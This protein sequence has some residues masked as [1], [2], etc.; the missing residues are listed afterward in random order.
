MLVA[1]ILIFR[2]SYDTNDDSAMNLIVA[3]KLIT[4]E[5]DE[6]MIFTHVA[7]GMVL[8]NLY[9]RFPDLPWYALYLFAVQGL[10]HIALLYAL[11]TQDNRPRTLLLFLLY[12]T[13]IGVLFLGV[14]QFTT[15]A[16]LVGQ[17]GLFLAILA[18]LRAADHKNRDALQLA[19]AGAA[20]LLLSSMIRWPVFFLVVC[21]AAPIALVMAWCYRRERRLLAAS[22][23]LV[24]ATTAAAYGLVLLNHA[25][26]AADPRWQDF[27]EFNEL[28]AKFNDLA[29]VYYS[30]ET[31]PV[32]AT[33]GWSANDLG[34]IMSWFYDDPATF[35]PE[36]LQRI[37]DSYAWNEGGY[38]VVK[39]HEFITEVARDRRL[40]PLLCLLPVLYLAL[41]KSRRVH[42]A[43]LLTVVFVVA[44]ITAT[45][46][47]R[48]PPPAR[49][50]LPVLA[51]PSAL[52]LFCS[53]WH[54]RG[55]TSNANPH[56]STLTGSWQ[57]NRVGWSFV[58]S[59]S[60]MLGLYAGI[61]NMLEQY[62]RGKQRR[63]QSNHFYEQLARL[64]P[65][66][67]NL[68]VCW[69]AAMPFEHIR[70]IDNL[71][72]LAGFRALHMGWPQQCPFHDDMKERFDVPYLAR[73]LYER[74]NVI[75]IAHPACLKLYANYV[76][77]HFSTEISFELLGE[78]SEAVL[79]RASPT[80]AET[81]AS[82]RTPE[83][84]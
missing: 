9:E 65:R 81:I 51:F 52:A 74:S 3:G 13:V 38:D 35:G 79:A 36:R 68:Y 2:P 47:L 76:R 77:E 41:G 56:A 61:L 59:L 50:Y 44:L 8:K 73:Q 16:F 7:I 34:M 10:A 70:P 21:L 12:S 83:S 27:Y 60:V 11:I 23:G 15:T 26:Y 62:D 53:A 22:A 17:S 28:R 46:I 24:I 48:K 5:P 82:Q 80:G 69:G 37:L 49:V 42:A 43:V 1:S 14:L 4:A 31:A 66:P 40:I 32:L 54:A 64:D 29:W 55:S 72:W 84:Q 57:W 33:N 71:Q 78:L 67:D 6:H 75:L 39:L 58:V 30:S 25:Y 19:A 45:I 18:F 20:L 63:R